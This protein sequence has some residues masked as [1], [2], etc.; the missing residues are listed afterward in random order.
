MKSRIPGPKALL[1]QVRDDVHCLNRVAMKIKHVV[2]SGAVPFH[3]YGH[4]RHGENDDSPVPR[5]VPDDVRIGHSAE[6]KS[7][8]RR[9]LEAIPMEQPLGSDADSTLSLDVSRQEVESVLL[10]GVVD[11]VDVPQSGR[12]DLGGNGM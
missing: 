6:S 2:L 4:N 11:M 5:T 10:E 1:L 9:C 3:P 7:R 8:G 12:A